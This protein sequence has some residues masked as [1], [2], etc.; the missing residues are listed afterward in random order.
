MCIIW[1][2]IFFKSQVRGGGTASGDLFVLIGANKSSFSL[3]K[4]VQGG[5]DASGA[6]WP[7][8]VIL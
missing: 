1:E 2:G 7:K 5:D 3:G 4:Q 6:F 8:K